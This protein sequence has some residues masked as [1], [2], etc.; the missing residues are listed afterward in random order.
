MGTPRNR[1]EQWVADGR[2]F[3]EG[4]KLF[5]GLKK[6]QT[7]EQ[8]FKR[9]TIRSQAK[10]DHVLKMHLRSKPA[11]ERWK[12]TLPTAHVNNLVYADAPVIPD[13]GVPGAAHRPASGMTSWWASVKKWWHNL[14]SDGQK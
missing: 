10:L 6:L 4:V 11:E 9:N 3:D 7:L 8:M 2:P 12:E 14:T 1:Y 5:R 13:S